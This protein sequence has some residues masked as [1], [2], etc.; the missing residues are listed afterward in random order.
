MS[1]SNE[2]NDKVDKVAHPSSIIPATS[3]DTPGIHNNFNFPFRIQP[4]HIFFGTA[5]PLCLGAYLGFTRQMNIYK[6][7]AAAEAVAE[8]MN[9]SVTNIVT[10]EG[11]IMAGRALAV[12]TMSSVGGFALMG[13]GTFTEIFLECYSITRLL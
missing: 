3:R 5:V 13:A 1:A 9:A 12:A 2:S 6:K 4:G 7:E 11:K 8:A 10:T